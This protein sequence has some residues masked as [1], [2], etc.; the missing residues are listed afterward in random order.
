MKGRREVALLALAEAAAAT[1]AG[2]SSAPPTFR[3][4]RP[5]VF[6]IRERHSGSIVFVGKVDDPTA[7]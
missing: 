1:S 4:D 6:M 7:G 2:P 3:A 5:F